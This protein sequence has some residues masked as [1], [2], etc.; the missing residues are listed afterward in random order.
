M[1]RFRITYISSYDDDCTSVWTY[2]DSKAEAISY[3]KCEYHDIKEIIDCYEI[4]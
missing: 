4:K 2:A 3:V 1:K